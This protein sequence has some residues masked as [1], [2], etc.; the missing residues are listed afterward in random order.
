[1]K[2]MALIA[3]SLIMGTSSVARAD[4]E[5]PACYQVCE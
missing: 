4:V 1:M 3:V 2:T 5:V